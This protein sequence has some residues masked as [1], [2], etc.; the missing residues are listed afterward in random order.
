M[1]SGRFN[2]RTLWTS[3]SQMADE[4][5]WIS[6]RDNIGGEVTDDDGTGAKWSAPRF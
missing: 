6:N 1:P 3:L 4:A 5:S 2:N